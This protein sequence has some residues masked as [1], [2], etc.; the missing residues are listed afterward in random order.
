M[1]RSLVGSEMCI[2]DRYQR[3]V[4]GF[5]SETMAGLR[6]C[7]LLYLALAETAALQP[8]VPIE[9]GEAITELG[10]GNDC[11]GDLS[12]SGDECVA[13]CPDGEMISDD[14]VCTACPQGEYTDRV[15]NACVQ[16]CPSDAENRFMDPDHMD[17]VKTCPAGHAPGADD[18][19]CGQCQDGEYADHVAHKCVSSCPT[20]G[21]NKY[22]DGVGK[23]CVDTCLLYTSPSPRDS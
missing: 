13:R 16:E 11:P 18:R 17:C 21:A 3:R 6:I 14:R 2:R 1:L 20:N 10:D 19:K 22:S 12:K 4:R 8:L 7:L 9:L 15:V 5:R 23:D